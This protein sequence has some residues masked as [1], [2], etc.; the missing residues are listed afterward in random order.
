MGEGGYKSELCKHTRIQVMVSLG[1][2]SKLTRSGAAG[3]L[4]VGH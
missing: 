3:Q 2:I 1:T 4:A